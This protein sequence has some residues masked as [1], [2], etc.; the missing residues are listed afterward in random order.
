MGQLLSGYSRHYLVNRPAS[1]ST[2]SYQCNDDWIRLFA[3]GGLCRDPLGKQARTLG[4]NPG[5][6]GFQL[7]LSAAISY[8][9]D[10]RSSELGCADGIFYYGPRSGTTLSPSKTTR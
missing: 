6:V 9:H 5:Y 1:A 10:R 2:W 3:G 7:F 8:L 4:F